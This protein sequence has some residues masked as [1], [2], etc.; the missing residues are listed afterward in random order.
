M[1][2]H[3]EHYKPAPAQRPEPVRDVL[4]ALAI[5]IVLAMLAL[6][7]FDVLWGPL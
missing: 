5:G 6:A 2:A 1:S 7:Y 3:R 4:T